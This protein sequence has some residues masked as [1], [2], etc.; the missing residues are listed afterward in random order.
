MPSHWVSIVGIRQSAEGK[1]DPTQNSAEGEAREIEAKKAKERQGT[2]T[3]ICED[4][5]ESYGRADEAVAQ[6]VGISTNTIAR[7]KK[8]IEHKDE[9]DPEDFKNWDEGKLT[10]KADQIT[11]FFEFIYYL[12][13]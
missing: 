2:R 5:H 6:K 9:I 12:Y 8:I 13:I 1:A 3:D 7:E 11:A 4:S 10:E